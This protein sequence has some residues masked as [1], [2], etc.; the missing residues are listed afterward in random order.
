MSRWRLSTDDIS[1]MKSPSHSANLRL[2]E[3]NGP[4]AARKRV[5]GT[6]QAHY[7]SGTC[8]RDLAE[9]QKNSNVRAHKKMIHVFFVSCFS[10]CTKRWYFVPLA[11]TIDLDSRTCHSTLTTLYWPRWPVP[12]NSLSV[13]R[14]FVNLFICGK[15]ITHTSYNTLLKESEPSFN[16]VL[17][18][19]RFV[20]G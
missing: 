1:G 3:V 8:N 20:T 7:R 4:V 5:T 16:V 10:K 18:I 9:Q 13:V 19:T 12:W 6:N 17:T 14:Q 11:T 15:T 2:G